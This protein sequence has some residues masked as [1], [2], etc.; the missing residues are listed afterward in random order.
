MTAWLL[1]FALG[2]TLLLSAGL[3]AVDL[4]AT[5]AYFVT[6]TGWG[7]HGVQAALAFLILFEVAAGTAVILRLR[8]ERWVY[9]AVLGILVG[10]TV[11]SGGLALRG[12][13]SC[14]CFGTRFA[15]PPVFTIFKNVALIAATV[16]LYRRSTSHHPPLLQEQVR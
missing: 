9:L 8:P 7:L 13:E 10:F 14:G 12:V 16:V 5:A 4:Q 6:L 1:R 11:G 3:K 15:F 2:G